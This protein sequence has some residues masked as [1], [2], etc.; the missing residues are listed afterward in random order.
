MSDNQN[1]IDEQLCSPGQM[2]MRDVVQSLPEDT[3]SMAWRSSLNEKILEGAAK[4]RQRR[5]WLWFLAPSAGLAVACA[6][7]T[8]V[9]L[10]VGRHEQPADR[11]LEAAMVS[12]HRDLS[13]TQDVTGSGLNALE[14][15]NDVSSKPIDTID[16][17]E[18]DIESL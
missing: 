16:L 5:R 4:K 2:A 9:I 17:N 3:L 14:T 8:V 18:S 10:G 11:G 13:S 7:A 12:M 15:K 1:R 6:L